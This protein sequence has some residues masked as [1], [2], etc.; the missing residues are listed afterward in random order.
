MCDP[1]RSVADAILRHAL[2]DRDERVADA[3]HREQDGNAGQ[4]LADTAGA[5]R[6]ECR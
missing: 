1:D 4:P 5:K 3:E 6:E 2:D